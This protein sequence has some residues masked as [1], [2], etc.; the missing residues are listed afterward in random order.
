MSQNA[1]AEPARTKSGQGTRMTRQRALILSELKSVQSHPT[2][3]EIYGMVRKKMPRISLGTVY[4]NLDLLAES[5]EVLKLEYAGFQKRFDGN[6]HAHQ[7]V[8]CVHCGKVADVMPEVDNPTLPEK[9]NV[10]GFTVLSA[11]V[12]F[13]GVCKDCV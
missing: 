6:T 8:R 3:D 1:Q 4:R 7:H 13:F 12:E 10:P 9:M 2:A 11:R 5:S